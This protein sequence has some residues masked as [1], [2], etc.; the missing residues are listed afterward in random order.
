M[1]DGEGPDQ[2]VAAGI[3]GGVDLATEDRPG[4]R[5]CQVDCELR[6]RHQS[7]GVTLTQLGSRGD[8]SVEGAVCFGQHAFGGLGGVLS[9][10]RSARPS[11]SPA[12]YPC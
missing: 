9:P 7:G 5:E 3:D 4:E 8:D 6:E 2:G 11:A 10:R 1:L 12:T